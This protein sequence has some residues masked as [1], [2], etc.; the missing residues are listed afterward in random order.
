[1][2]LRALLIND[3]SQVRFIERNRYAARHVDTITHV[4]RG[5]TNE[6]SA[7]VSCSGMVMTAG[8]L[9][10]VLLVV[11]KFSLE[12]SLTPSRANVGT[13]FEK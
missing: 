11:E 9:G 5:R 10:L 13:R 7:S 4:R 2:C 8:E 1:M 12:S 6:S 3:I